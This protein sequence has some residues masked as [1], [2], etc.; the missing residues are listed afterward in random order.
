M[1]ND[2]TFQVAFKIIYTSKKSHIILLSPPF[3]RILNFESGSI[4]TRRSLNSILLINPETEK[5]VIK[6][7]TSNSE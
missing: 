2:Y 4:S 6:V 5:R 3:I 1:R 7:L